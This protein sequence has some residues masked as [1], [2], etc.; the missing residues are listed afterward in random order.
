MREAIEK[1]DVESLLTPRFVERTVWI[2]LSLRVLK[3]FNILMERKFTS[4]KQLGTFPHQY[5]CGHQDPPDHKV[6]P[7]YLQ[8][9]RLVGPQGGGHLS[10]YLLAFQFSSIL[11]DDFETKP[12]KKVHFGHLY[13]NK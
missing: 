11:H 2:G 6:I 1:R 12:G 4:M 13:L 5:R 9:H 10:A 8:H 3:T 7:Y